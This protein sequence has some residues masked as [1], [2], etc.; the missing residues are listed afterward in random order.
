MW[1]RNGLAVCLPLI[2]FASFVFCWDSCPHEGSGQNAATNRIAF[3]S[4]QVWALLTSLQR[5]PL[6][7]RASDVI[8]LVPGA[9]PTFA[10]YVGQP[11]SL[12]SYNHQRFEA[13]P[14]RVREHHR[15]MERGS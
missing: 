7:P 15:P 13:R 14:T 8:T 6:T 1:T 9:D 4:L 11:G 12:G 5:R 10:T 2:G 3:A